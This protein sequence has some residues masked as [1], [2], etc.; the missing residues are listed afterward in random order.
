MSVEFVFVHGFMGSQR[1]FQ[2]FPQDLKSEFKESSVLHY[3][4][5]TRGEWDSKVLQLTEYLKNLPQ[6][7]SKIIIAHSM[8]GPLSV[9]AALRLGETANI[10]A[11]ISYDSPFFGIHPKVI[12]SDGMER[13]SGTISQI[14][15]G[16]SSVLNSFSSPRTD[17]NGKYSRT[18]GGIAAFSLA[19][20][21][22]TAYNSS[23]A[24]KQVVDRQYE[25]QSKLF[26]ESIAFLGP[27]SLI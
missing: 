20:T 27:V 16:F 6:N 19:A 21:A 18:I 26:Q 24:V 17:S 8:G 2:Q 14:T 22:F 7:A 5:E 13:V 3:E 11:I 10:R 4:Y 23:P 1:S 15:S 9:D 12:A 25:A